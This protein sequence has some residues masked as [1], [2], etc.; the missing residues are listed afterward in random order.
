M[1]AEPSTLA[2]QWPLWHDGL[3]VRIR[4]FLLLV[5]DN[6][7][8]DLPEP[9]QDHQWRLRWSMLQVFF[10]SPTVHYEV[11]VQR[12]AGRIEIGLHFESVREESYRWARALAERSLEIQAQLGPSVELEEW[13]K[14]WTRLHETLPLADDLTDELAEEA[15]GRLARFMEVLEPIVVQERTGVL[16]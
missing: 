7:A 11:W 9:L 6:L 4:D 8:R 5:H 2:G 14:N 3:A 13:T 15:G 1:V 12:K 16:G 10:E